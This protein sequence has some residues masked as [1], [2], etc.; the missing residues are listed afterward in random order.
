MAALGFFMPG[1]AAVDHGE[2]GTTCGRLEYLL[3][4]QPVYHTVVAAAVASQATPLAARTKVD[5]PV[6]CSIQLIRTPPCGQILG[7]HERIENSVRRNF[8][9][10]FAN[11]RIGDT[12]PPGFR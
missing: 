7:C 1:E 2:P 10:N 8:D 4:I 9:L 12:G 3:K 11:D 6:E 5:T